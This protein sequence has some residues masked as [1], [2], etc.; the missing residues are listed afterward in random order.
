[1]KRERRS[2]NKS[3]REVS[4]RKP[5]LIRRK[6]LSKKKI[7]RSMCFSSDILFAVCSYKYI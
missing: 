2:A 1:M 4:I 6:L 3:K 5:E 7:R